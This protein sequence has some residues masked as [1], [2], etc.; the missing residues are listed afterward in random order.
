MLSPKFFSD[1]LPRLKVV[2]FHGIHHAWLGVSGVHR[3]APWGVS[4]LPLNISL[5]MFN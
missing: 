1:I 4:V 5:S 3:V 2:G